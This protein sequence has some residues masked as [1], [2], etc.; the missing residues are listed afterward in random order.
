[1]TQR[2]PW[3]DG[4]GNK[5]LWTTVQTGPS[6]LLDR[7]SHRNDA[8]WAQIVEARKLLIEK[9]LAW[10]AAALR[11]GWS[12]HP[13]YQCEPEQRAFSLNRNGFHVQ[14][15]ARPSTKDTGGSG[16]ITCWGPDGL[17]IAVGEIYDWAA[18]R[19]GMTTCAYCHKIGVPTERVGFAG[20]CCAG[21]LPDMRKVIETPGWT[22]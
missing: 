21:C 7:V 5:G 19:A 6:F 12:S 20:R 16:E 11:D 2:Q 18:I 13:T 9:A 22:A 1:M 14:G 4:I 10:R 17:H 15:L 8:L 3:E